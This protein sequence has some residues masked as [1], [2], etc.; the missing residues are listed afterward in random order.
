MKTI[1]AAAVASVTKIGVIVREISDQ[2]GSRLMLLRMTETASNPKN[3]ALTR[4]VISRAAAKL[5]WKFS[6]KKTNG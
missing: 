6:A 4:K 1:D 5:G 2:Y 3:S